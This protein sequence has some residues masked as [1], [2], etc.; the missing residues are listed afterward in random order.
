MIM[1]LSVELVLL[2]ACTGRAD[3]LEELHNPPVHR[4][5]NNKWPTMIA[6]GVRLTFV[7][8]G[9]KSEDLIAAYNSNPFSS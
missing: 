2:R 4:R 9:L 5:W 1:L 6:D 8:P 7:A 3:D